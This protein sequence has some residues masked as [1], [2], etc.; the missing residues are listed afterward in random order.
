MK[1]SCGRWAVVRRLSS[2]GCGLGE[3][4][5]LIS[6]SLAAGMFLAGTARGQTEIFVVPPGTA[7]VTPEE[8]YAP[9]AKAATNIQTAVTFAKN[10]SIGTVTV[11]NGTYN[12]TSEILVAGPITLRS[13]EGGLSGASNT[14][15]RR[16]G[17]GTMR[18]FNITDANAVLQGL[19]F[20]NGYGVAG[21][22]VSMAG[23]L[24]RDCIIANNDALANNGGGVYMNGGTVSNCI[25]RSNRMGVNNNSAGDGGGIYATGTSKIFNCHILSNRAGVNKVENEG[26]GVFAGSSTVIRNCLIADN[27][28][29]RR[30]GGVYTS[31]RIE[32]CTIVGNWMY[33]TRTDSAGGGVYMTG[34]SVSNSIVYFNAITAESTTGYTNIYAAAGVGYTC[35]TGP[36]FSAANGNTAGDPL[37]VNRSGGDYSLQEDSPCMDTGANQDDWMVG[38]TDLAGNARKQWGGVAD[39]KAKIVDMGAY[40]AP[41]PPPAATIILLR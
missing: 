34:G 8:P 3:S 32:N 30:G 29:W 27:R 15:V 10:N 39:G 35:T 25:V 37:F 2:L 31:G 26:G 20:T 6:L 9:W 41:T 4:G 5:R 24:V 19:S 7:S 33:G 1:T 38:A 18:I 13:F 23:G 21:A 16:S 36:E 17:S 14:V 28:T 40:E 22:G 11:S 12:I